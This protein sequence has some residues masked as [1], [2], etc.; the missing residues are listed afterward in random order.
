VALSPQLTLS[1]GLR[2]E[3]HPGYYDKY[4][5]IGNFDPSVA[6]AGRVIYPTGKQ[7]LLAQG[8]LA[9]ANACDADGVNN[10]LGHCQRRSLHAGGRQPGSRLP[11]GSEDVPT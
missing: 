2:Y 10:Q 4:G 7:D 3:L 5:D 8:F 9:S 6:L 11:V 1:Y